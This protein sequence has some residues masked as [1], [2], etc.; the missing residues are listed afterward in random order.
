[1]T[2]FVLDEQDKL[3]GVNED[4]DTGENQTA[5][6]DGVFEYIGA[7]LSTGFFKGPGITE[8]HGYIETNGK[9]E[10]KIPGFM[11]LGTALASLYVRL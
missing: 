3:A 7:I 6:C 10:T 9:M 11:G 5:A 2:E 4:K 8:A 1:M